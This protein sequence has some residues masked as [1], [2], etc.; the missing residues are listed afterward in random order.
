MT[1]SKDMR[2]AAL[3]CIKKGSTYSQTCRMFNI[4][5]SSLQ[6]WMKAPSLDRARGFTRRRKIDAEA[7]R[8]H[9][10]THPQMYLRER[11]EIFGVAINSMHY[12]LKRLNIV[13]KTTDDTK[14]AVLCKGSHT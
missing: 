12:A 8:A 7:L 10:K 11:A 13:K 6:R 1:Y 9:V 5:P 3:A 14:S 2:L 4:S